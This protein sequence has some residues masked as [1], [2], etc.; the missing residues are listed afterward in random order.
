MLGIFND[1]IRKL[2][3][4]FIPV[5]TRHVKYEAVPWFNDQIKIAIGSKYDAY[6]AVKFNVDPNR[7]A[8]LK[9]DLSDK[10][11]AVKKLIENAKSKSFVDKYYRATTLKSKWSVIKHLGCNKGADKYDG[12]NDIQNNFNL[13]EMNEY[14]ASIHTSDGANI[15]QL[16]TNPNANDAFN[17]REIDE[18]DF[19]NAF[20]KI[21]S[22]AVGEDEIPIKFLKLVLNELAQV[23]VVIFNFCIKNGV[24]PDVWNRIEGLNAR[25]R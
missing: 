13:N 23:I 16:D 17:F 8:D 12:D 1:K 20:N 10:Q 19:L 14:L 11:A 3:N 2:M 21:K 9:K 15:E 24:Y 25:T 5:K 6:H 4:K 22:N 7:N 18:N